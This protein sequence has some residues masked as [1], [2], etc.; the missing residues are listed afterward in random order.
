MRTE[1]RCGTSRT[2][3]LIIFERCDREHLTNLAASARL[4][5]L[6]VEVGVMDSP[7]SAEFRLRCLID[8]RSAVTNLVLGRI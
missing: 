5:T 1:G 4:S 7:A 6:E 8:Q 3:P 2:L